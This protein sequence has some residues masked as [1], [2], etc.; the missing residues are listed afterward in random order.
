MPKKVSPSD[1][2]GRK[3]NNNDLTRREAVQAAGAAVTAAALVGAVEFPRIQKV[4]AANSVV[5][6]AV[7]GTGSRGTYHLK[8]WKNI[9]NSQCI[10][11]CDISDEALKKALP[12]APG[13][14]QTYKD[15]RE[16]LSRKDIDAVQIA[17]PLYTHFPITKDSLLAG[18]HVFCEKSLVFKADEVHA[19][20]A[21]V[22][23]R[24]KQVMQVGLQRRYSEFY[25][26]AKQMIAKGMI[27]DVTHMYAQWNRNPGWVFKKTAW[28]LFKEYS[29]GLTAEL[30]SHQIDVADWMFG[31]HP[32]FVVGVGGIDYWKDG[33]TVYDNIQLIFKYP[34]GQ[35]L[36]YSAISTNNHLSMFQGERTEFGERIMGTQGTI[37]ITVGT[38]N[39]PAI[40]L[41]YY[42]PGPKVEA[43]AKKKEGPAPASASLLST[44]KGGR[45]LPILL[46]KDQI[47]AN[48][49]FVSKEMKFARRW[50]YS[51]GVMMPEETKNPVDVQLEEFL[52][53]VRTGKRPKADIEVGLADSTAVILSN[54]AMDEGRRVY[55]EEI[56]K[57]GKA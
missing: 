32:E 10:A 37:E 13:K 45:P 38:D 55:M 46:A 31:A 48:D 12:E 16:V 30:A 17:T 51:K 49:G 4:R 5:N 2:P 42:E 1:A 20:R 27:G 34:K 25:Q 23:E 21:L 3:A 47:G 41:W 26:M 29:G 28:R 36:M 39:E 52:D 53:C 44:G 7:I 6:Y 8:H 54:I 33:R 14:P 11:I 22:A 15:Y 56:E 18:K 24:P 50:L 35:K 40:G 57:I 19:L 9:D 43:A